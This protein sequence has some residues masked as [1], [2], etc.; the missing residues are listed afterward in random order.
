MAYNVQSTLYVIQCTPYSVRRTVYGIQCTAYS[1]CTTV[2]GLQCTAYSVWCTVYS[3]KFT[4]YGV[5]CT[6][7]SVQCTVHS[8]QYTTYTAHC[9]PAGS[10][11]EFQTLSKHFQRYL[12]HLGS[13]SLILSGPQ[14]LLDV[15][16]QQEE[17]FTHLC[18]G[19]SPFTSFSHIFVKKIY[20]RPQRAWIPR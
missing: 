9:L 12:G 20:P 7:Y 3:L 18:M 10:K 14:M 17:L 6:V 13:K 19:A 4:V 5:Q 2:Y 8:G 11:T 15:L 16:P 1:H